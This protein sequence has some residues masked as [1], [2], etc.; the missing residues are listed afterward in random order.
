MCRIGGVMVQQMTLE[1]NKLGEKPTGKEGK[2]S[3]QRLWK[4][5]INASRRN[6]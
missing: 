4:L 6:E 5:V 2:K 1:R 3:P